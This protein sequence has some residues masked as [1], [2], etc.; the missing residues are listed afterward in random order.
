MRIVFVGSVRFSRAMLQ[1]LLG[2]QAEIV[3]VVGKPQTGGTS[4]L[5]ALDDLAGAANVP[6][7]H[8]HSLKIPDS[9]AWIAARKPDVVFCCGWSEI[10]PPDVLAAAPHGV[11]GYHPALLPRNRGR[12]PVIWALALG[13]TETGSTFFL[14]D[15]GA[16]SGPILSQQRVPIEDDM[17][18][19]ALYSRLETVAGEQIE[20]VWRGLAAGS[21]KPK[22]QDHGRATYW[23]KRSA[24]DGRVDWRMP[25]RGIC[26]LVRA[27]AR[28]YPGA[29]FV[30]GTGESVV[31]RAR[32][33][34][35]PSADIEPGRIIEAGAT[36]TIKTGDGAVELVEWE[37]R[38]DFRVGETL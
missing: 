28:P 29:T 19:G 15:E 24:A 1:R 3:G 9:I 34:V 22:P 17:N 18:A 7:H 6:L 38:R 25:T 26:N 37:P 16:D 35:A 14:M 21:L 8:A 20:Q 36:V 12:H 10:L 5:A 2:L 4:D 30:D 33:A 27:L 23:R 32:P 11:V 31:W 13:L